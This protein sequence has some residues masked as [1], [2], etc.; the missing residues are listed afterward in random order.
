MTCVNPYVISI[1]RAFGCGRCYYCR[2]KK[3]KVWTHRIILEANQHE[4]N[5]FITLTYNDDNLPKGGTLVKRDLQLFFKRLRKRIAPKKVRYFAVGEYGDRG[6]RPHYHVALFGYPPCFEGRIDRGSICVCPSCTGIAESWKSSD[7]VSLGFIS[8]G[9]LEP[10]SAAYV[11]KYATK[12]MEE[13]DRDVRYPS[14][15]VPPFSC[16]SLK[17]GIGTQF[18]DN[19]V[20]ELIR[21][22][23]TDISDLP[24]YLSHGTIRR[25]IG[26]YIRNKI[27]ERVGITKQRA[28]EYAYE[29]MD[30]EMQPMRKLALK[31][32]AGS[33]HFAFKE[34]LVESTEVKRQQIRFKHK[35]KS[36]RKL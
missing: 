29:K 30:E 35:I 27:R 12:C 7:G 13:G 8:V 2:I 33:R 25:P 14:G 32:P 28:V 26:R 19:I 3:S 6:R 9:A 21:A 11:A 23:K 18:C 15:C 20:T 31:A 36:R 22:G 5:A 16:Q 10:A 1:G 24:N 17:P 34:I 4:E